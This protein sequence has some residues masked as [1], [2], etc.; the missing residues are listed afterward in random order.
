[1]AMESKVRNMGKLK[2]LRHLWSGLRSFLRRRRRIEESTFLQILKTL[3][4]L[5]SFIG[6]EFHFTLRLPVLRK[7]GS[8]GLTQAR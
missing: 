1:M 7:H 2:S 3:Q 5:L 4:Q 8:E 6:G